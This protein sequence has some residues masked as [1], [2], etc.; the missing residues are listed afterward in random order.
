MSWICG[1]YPCKAG[2]VA[3]ARKRF[4]ANPGE[5][6][7]NR[8]QYDL[9]TGVSAPQTYVYHCHIVE[10]EDNDMMRAFMVFLKPV[11]T[12]KSDASNF[13]SVKLNIL[14]A[15]EC[16]RYENAFSMN[17]KFLAVIS[18]IGVAALSVS[19]ASAQAPRAPDTL[20]SGRTMEKVTNPQAPGGGPGL[21]WVNTEAGVYHQQRSPFYG[22]TE[23]GKYMTEQD[24]IRAGFKR[25][26]KG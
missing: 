22:T 4:K 17:T 26:P 25:A 3:A 18:M 16:L 6:T 24:A 5:F 2:F 9:P 19:Q 10:H 8:A 15:V 11:Q 13:R 7:T 23:K 21:V 14:T 1:T 20:S 12:A